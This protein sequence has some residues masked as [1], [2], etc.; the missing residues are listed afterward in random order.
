[1]ARDARGAAQIVI[2]VGMAIRALPR[3]NR[4]RPRQ[5]KSYG[6]VVEIRVQPIVKAVAVLAT[7]RELAGYVIRIRGLLVV[8]GVAGIALRR[9]PLKLPGGRTG[10]AG[11]TIERRMRPQQWKAILVLVDLLGPDSP[12]L[13]GVALLAVCAELPLMNVGVAVRASLSYIG[14]DRLD[15]ALRAVHVLVQAPKWKLSLIVIE[16][17]NGTDRS[18]GGRRV[19]VLAGRVQIS[20]RTARNGGS[21]RSTSGSCARGQEHQRH[22]E[23]HYDRRNHCARLQEESTQKAITRTIAKL[24]KTKREE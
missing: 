2:V 23:M 5:W 17:G 19:A 13:D 7:D 10:V 12:A 3:R 4:V 11:I 1:V 18:P 15:V 8:L 20:V 9:E 6:C 14:K 22:H 24:R 21:L 16:L